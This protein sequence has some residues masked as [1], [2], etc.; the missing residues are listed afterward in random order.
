M[1]MMDTVKRL[2]A[3]RSE[4][5]ERTIDKA[6]DY[7]GRSSETLKRQAETAKAKARELDP[8][9]PGGT[10]PGD[11]PAGGTPTGATPAPGASSSLPLP[12]PPPPPPAPPVV[13]PTEPP[14]GG[15]VLR[16]DLAQPPEVPPAG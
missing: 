13:P 2:M 8:E 10:S 7:L 9:H 6:V 1:A 4:A 16:G 14:A 12:T 3:G 11:P 15:S 5:V